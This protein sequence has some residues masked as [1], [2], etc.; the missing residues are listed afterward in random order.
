MKQEMLVK[1]LQDI[2]SEISCYD[3][4]WESEYYMGSA[5]PTDKLK[6]LIDS[7]G[8]EEVDFC[9]SCMEKGR[10]CNCSNST[11]PKYKYYIVAE[12]E[13]CYPRITLGKRYEAT[14][15]KKGDMCATF[16]DDNGESCGVSL[17]GS[18]QLMGGD[19]TLI[20]EEE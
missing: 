9:F 17:K 10:Y 11:I 16:I 1:V 19:W 6:L 7:L 18:G 20:V 2:L 15:Y 3:N 14:N 8:G 4:E 5:S 12:G 13:H